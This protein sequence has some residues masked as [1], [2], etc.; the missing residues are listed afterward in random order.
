M[1]PVMIMSMITIT[2]IE[3]LST[4]ASARHRTTLRGMGIHPHAHAGAHTL[5]RTR[6]CTHAHAFTHSFTAAHYHA[7]VTGKSM[8]WGTA[9]WHDARL[10]RGGAWT[11]IIRAVQIIVHLFVNDADAE[12]S[13]SLHCADIP[14]LG[15]I[16][17]QPVETQ[18][19]TRTP[20]VRTT[21]DAS[22]AHQPLHVEAWTSMPRA[23][24]GAVASPLFR[25]SVE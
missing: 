5:T 19:E 9:V 22:R 20:L 6:T 23:L 17:D 10:N 13:L 25:I 2:T 15:R 16:Y 4:G 7:R 8:R 12:Q 21:R 24:P 11:R 14:H 1:L 18:R 3:P